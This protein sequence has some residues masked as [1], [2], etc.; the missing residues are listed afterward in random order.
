MRRFVFKL[1]PNN[2][3]KITILTTAINL[4]KS[5]Q[6]FIDINQNA[7]DIKENIYLMVLVLI[8]KFIFY[9]QF[10]LDETL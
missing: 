3:Y 7:T 9:V 2:N 6:Q 1:V 4:I 10:H 5:T 8:F